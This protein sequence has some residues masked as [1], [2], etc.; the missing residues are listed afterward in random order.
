MLPACSLVPIRSVII[1]SLLI[2]LIVILITDGLR[3]AQFNL[4]FVVL[5]LNLNSSVHEIWP[6]C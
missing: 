6:L 1:S 3:I 5:R 2:N 4:A